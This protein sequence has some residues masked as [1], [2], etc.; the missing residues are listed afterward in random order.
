[1]KIKSLSLVVLS[2]GVCTLAYAA[3][4]K[5]PNVQLK[6]ASPSKVETKGAEFSE[7]Y[8]VEGAAKTD[9]GIASEKESEREPSS[10]VAADKKQ[11]PVDEKK[12]EAFGPKPWLYKTKLDSAY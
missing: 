4:Y 7:G 5:A 11:D 10:T 1:M 6:L 12:D 3:D 9:R 2:L 8:K